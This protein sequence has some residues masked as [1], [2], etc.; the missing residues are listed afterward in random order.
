MLSTEHFTSYCSS[1]AFPE[2]MKQLNE[3]YQITICTS[4]LL[5]VTHQ[6]NGILSSDILSSLRAGI[7][8]SFS[9][10]FPCDVFWKRASGHSGSK[11]KKKSLLLCVILTFELL[12]IFTELPWL[13]N[14]TGP[15]SFTR[16]TFILF[17]FSLKW[18]HY[19]DVGI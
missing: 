1:L 16:L 3:D 11:A 6:E 15:E 9:I 2:Q 7:S 14:C 12:W 5:F 18:F 19:Y 17:P 13:H 4:Q 10:Y 8:R